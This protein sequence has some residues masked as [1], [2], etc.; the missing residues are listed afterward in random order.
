MQSKFVQVIVCRSDH[1]PRDRRLSEGLSPRL[2]WLTEQGIA[3][4]DNALLSPGLNV[5]EETV[6]AVLSAEVAILL[7]S[8]DWFQDPLMK[9]VE[10]LLLA[11]ARESGLHLVPVLLRPCLYSS[12]ALAHFPPVNGKPIGKMTSVDRENIWD[13]VI[14]RVCNLVG[15]RLLPPTLDSLVT[16]Q[17]L[18]SLHATFTKHTHLQTSLFTASGANGT[19]VSHGLGT[20]PDRVLLAGRNGQ[21]ISTDQVGSTTLRLITTKVSPFTGLAIARKE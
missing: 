13:N 11:G 4:W 8:I 3:I 19:T 7:V 1:S 14:S 6:Q 21:E 15:I 12:S 18:Y 5:I 10:P 16:E 17:Y 9:Q 20:I 2:S